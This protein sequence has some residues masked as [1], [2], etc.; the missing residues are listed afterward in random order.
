MTKLEVLDLFRNNVK[1]LPR[2]IGNLKSLRCLW[3]EFNL[4]EFEDSIYDLDALVVVRVETDRASKLTKF[5]HF[6]FKETE[7]RLFRRVDQD[8]TVINNNNSII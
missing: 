7:T 8:K 4:V 3:I 1:K 2:D 5:D 6:L